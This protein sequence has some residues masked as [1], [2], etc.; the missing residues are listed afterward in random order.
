MQKIDKEKFSSAIVDHFKKYL[1]YEAIA[2]KLL[3]HIE[4]LSAEKMHYRTGSLLNRVGHH[5][6]VLKIW[7]P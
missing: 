1:S 3:Q 2:D 6:R 4:K 7:N 5:R